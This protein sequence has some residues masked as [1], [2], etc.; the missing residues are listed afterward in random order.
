MEFA[1]YRIFRRNG[2]KLGTFINM[3]ASREEAE[4]LSE[5]LAGEHRV[6]ELRTREIG[7][8]DDYSTVLFSDE[9]DVAAF[10]DRKRRG[11]ETNERQAKKVEEGDPRHFEELSLE[12]V[13]RELRAL[14]EHRDAQL[15]P[16]EAILV[17]ICI[18]DLEAARE[19][20]L[21]ERRVAEG[22]PV[23]TDDGEE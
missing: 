22:S 10:G 18:A 4:D 20:K 13:E 21:R 8:E 9:S 14:R 7:E 1:V 2:R 23:E 3:F 5:R 17:G 16:N 6:V 15:T 11:E 12:E 19:R